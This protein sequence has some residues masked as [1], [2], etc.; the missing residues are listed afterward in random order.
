[1][2]DELHERLD[3]FSLRLCKWDDM[4]KLTSSNEVEYPVIV[5][6]PD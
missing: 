2:P 3:A 6:L 5:A 4:H 1:M